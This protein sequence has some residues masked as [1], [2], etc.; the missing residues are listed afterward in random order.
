M[1]SAVGDYINRRMISGVRF[2]MVDYPKFEDYIRTKYAK[3]LAELD[4][5]YE[6]QRVQEP[7]VLDMQEVSI[8]D[9][10]GS[11][12]EKTVFD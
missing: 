9:Q 6:S 1:S 8:T 5:V 11:V 2:G 7:K 12:R 4:T 10:F 3:Q